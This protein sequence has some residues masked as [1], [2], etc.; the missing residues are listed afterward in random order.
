MSVP[1]RYQRK[2]STDL[3]V[4]IFPLLCSLEGGQGVGELVSL[5]AQRL[6]VDQ[7]PLDQRDGQL[8]IAVTVAEG[9][10]DSE[11]FRHER[12]EGYCDVH[13]G[14]H[15]D[16]DDRTTGILISAYVFPA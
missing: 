15:S 14:S 10:L 3:A 13:V 12:E 8:I 1:R 16:S 7:P 4:G 2:R 5:S 9:A 6:E 11:L